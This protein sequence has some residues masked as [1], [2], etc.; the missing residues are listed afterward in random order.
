MHNYILLN[1]I[2]VK[3]IVFVSLRAML[4]ADELGDY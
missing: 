1:P 3:L 2:N 4:K